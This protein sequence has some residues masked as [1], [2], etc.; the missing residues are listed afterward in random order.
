[1]CEFPYSNI[2]KWY[3]MEKRNIIKLHK[4]SN[5]DIQNILNCWYLK[6]KFAL[7]E[8]RNMGRMWL[9]VKI[10]VFLLGLLCF[11]IGKKILIY[12]YEI[13]TTVDWV[14]VTAGVLTCIYALA[15]CIFA[16]S[17]RSDRGGRLKYKD[18][19]KEFPSQKEYID[20]YYKR[21]TLLTKE[22]I[23]DGLLFINKEYDLALLTLRIE[24][25]GNMEDLDFN[26]STI[27]C[28]DVEKPEVDIVN[29]EVKISLDS[30]NGGLIE[31]E[32]IEII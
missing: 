4:F 8:R 1:M 23:V 20:R 31:F 21:Y 29:S 6:D 16:L 18:F 3:K 26:I 10:L 24:N 2:R 5:E 17:I 14:L 15:V 27:I 12:S 25:D 9:C 7:K 11:H 30:Y 13:I 32:G 22:N 19:C 28:E